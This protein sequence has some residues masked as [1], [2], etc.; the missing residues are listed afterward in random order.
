VNGS[1]YTINFQGTSTSG[2]HSAF[3]DSVRLTSGDSQTSYTYDALGR[4]VGAVSGD[5]T[6]TTT[7]IYGFDAASNRQMVT[8]AQADGTKLPIFRFIAASK[9]F[10]TTSYLEGRQA[11]ESSQG[12]GFF[13]LSSGGG[14]P[15]G[16]LSLLL[17]GKWRSFHFTSEQ[18]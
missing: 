14:G 18:L 10:Y 6:I 5:D 11:G 12:V 9:Y 3:I 15:N 13:L 17:C 8:V 1:T 2:D 7:S 4:L 16:T